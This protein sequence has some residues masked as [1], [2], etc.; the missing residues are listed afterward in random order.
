MVTLVR[1]PLTDIYWRDFTTWKI[2]AQREI[3][4]EKD[5]MNKLDKWIDKKKVQAINQWR[6]DWKIFVD[7]LGWV[8]L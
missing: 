6:K 8:T 7:W 3:E 1:I 4:Q 5:T 2:V